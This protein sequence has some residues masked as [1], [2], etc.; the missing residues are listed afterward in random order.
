MP[1]VLLVLYGTVDESHLCYH[2]PQVGLIPVT[3]SHTGTS[4]D[5]PN[6]YIPGFIHSQA[7]R[8]NA[9]WLLMLHTIPYWGGQMVFVLVVRG[10]S[11][12]HHWH[13]FD[14][15]AS[16][17]VTK[18]YVQ[19]TG[20]SVF[21]VLA[22]SSRGGGHLLY[23]TGPVFLSVTREFQRFETCLKFSLKFGHFTQKFPL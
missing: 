17:D 2:L 8:A 19:C 15:A 21:P 16:V 4:C 12:D 3:Q 6:V 14:Q 9:T 1:G 7:T 22:A 5:T 20:M 11:L 10:M 13:V 18:T 23:L